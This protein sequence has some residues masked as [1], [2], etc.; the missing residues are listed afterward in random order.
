MLTDLIKPCINKLKIEIHFNLKKGEKKMETKEM[1]DIQQEI[2]ER[3]P[4]ITFPNVSLQPL[5]YGRREVFQI[6]D[7]KAIVIQYKNEDPFVSAFCTESYSLTPFEV[8][9][10]KLIEAADI[11]KQTSGD[12]NLNIAVLKSGER[13]RVSAQF[14]TDKKPINK[15]DEVVTKVGFQTS[16]DMGWQHSPFYGATRLVCTNGMTANIIEK[17]MSHRHVQSLNLEKQKEALVQGASMMGQQINEWK[18]WSNKTLRKEEAVMIA[19]VLPFGE[20]YNEKILA[21]PE[22]GTGETLQ[23]WIDEDNVN[24]WR[25]YNIYT[26]F[27]SH[28]VESDLIR[29]EKGKEVSAIF[30]RLMNK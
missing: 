28:E 15:G 21:L 16:Y 13:M 22:T 7:R 9:V 2:R 26:Q 8:T 20:R 29:I 5:Q 4:K 18:N 1:I 12:Y 23:Q 14:N 10:K 6:P 24:A 25:M 30:H 11:V 17:I 27:L 3:F 19:E